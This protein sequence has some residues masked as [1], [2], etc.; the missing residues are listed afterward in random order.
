[1]RQRTEEKRKNA[2]FFHPLALTKDPVP[3]EKK[4]WGFSP[5]APSLKAQGE[6]LLSV[7]MVWLQIHIYLIGVT[8]TSALQAALLHAALYFHIL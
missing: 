1:M 2:S 7:L 6:H 5:L 3:L 8:S 4:L